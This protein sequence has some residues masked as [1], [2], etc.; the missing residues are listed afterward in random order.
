MCHYFD[1]IYDI[2]YWCIYDI[3]Y[4]FIYDIIYLIYDLLS[5]VCMYES[6]FKFLFAFKIYTKSSAEQ[7]QKLNH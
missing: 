6:L 1:I 4:W 3:I 2:I 5:L 7:S